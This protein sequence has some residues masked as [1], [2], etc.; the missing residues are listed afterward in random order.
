MGSMLS[1]AVSP[2]AVGP[3]EVQGAT[4]QEWGGE[5]RL[6]QAGGQEA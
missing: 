2:Q 6:C 5:E 4:C 3:W 1:V